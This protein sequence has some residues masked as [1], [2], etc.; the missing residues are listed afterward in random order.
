MPS[1]CRAPPSLRYFLRP[2]TLNLAEKIKDKSYHHRRILRLVLEDGNVKKV[3]FKMIFKRSESLCLVLEPLKHEQKLVPYAV[4]D[5]SSICL[6][7]NLL[8]VLSQFFYM[9]EQL[10]ILARRDSY[11]NP[12]EIPVYPNYPT[13]QNNRN[14]I[15]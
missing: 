4:F 6:L 8:A 9:W 3:S 5:V 15:Y 7:Q 14:K 11:Q 1:K 13:L 12:M 2:W 10:P